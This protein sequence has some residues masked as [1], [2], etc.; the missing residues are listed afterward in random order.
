MS[1]RKRFSEALRGYA[2][3]SHASAKK[4]PTASPAP[5]LRRRTAPAGCEE[6]ALVVLEDGYV[7]PGASIDGALSVEAPR[8]AQGL[9]ERVREHQQL[10]ALLDNVHMVL[11]QALGRAGSP[12]RPG[13][14]NGIRRLQGCIKEIEVA[15]YYTR[16]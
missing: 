6:S 4:S 2:S 5:T 11:F 15:S 7:S 9:A 10:C 12:D 1:H 3:A 8:V 13:L 16:P 14:I